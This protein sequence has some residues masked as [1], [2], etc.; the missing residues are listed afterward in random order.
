M[1]LCW[2]LSL[3]CWRLAA[4]NLSHQVLCLS[5]CLHLARCFDMVV[6]IVGRVGGVSVSGLV[7]G[8]AAEETLAR[9]GNAS[10]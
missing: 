1:Y 9:M 10:K 5:I 3:C 4:L 2:V 7:L 6:R 8:K